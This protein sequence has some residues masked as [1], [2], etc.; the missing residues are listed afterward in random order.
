MQTLSLF[1]SFLSQFFGIPHSNIIFLMHFL[2]ASTQS[3][4][5]LY[6]Q[7]YERQSTTDCCQSYVAVQNSQPQLN[8]YF[9]RIRNGMKIVF[10][11]LKSIFGIQSHFNEA[12]FANCVLLASRKPFRNCFESKISNI[13]IYPSFTPTST[14]S[15]HSV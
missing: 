3:E 15:L 6:L 4:R 9:F 11:L 7:I 13:R 1:S 14:H 12:A 8:K 10:H 2:L 5:D